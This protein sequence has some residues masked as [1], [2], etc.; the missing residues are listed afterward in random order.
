[1]RL[2]RRAALLGAAAAML[3]ASLPS[4]PA[5]A[6]GGRGASIQIDP[7]FPYYLD[8]SADSIADE[9][10]AN[11]YRTV[12]YFVVNELDVRTE[13]VKALRRRGITVW[14]MVVGLG[15]YS[16]ASWPQGWESWQMELLKPIDLGGFH[17]FS[18]FS[19]DYV[20]FKSGMIA[21]MLAATP[22]DGIEVAEPY[23][24]DWE[25]IDKGY[26]GDVG[27]LARAAFQRE[28][29]TAIP[30]FAD[31]A[32]PTYY[33]TD[34]ARYER[35]IQF[36]VDAVNRCV[37]EI[38]GAARAARPDLKVATWSL[39]VDG[40]PDSVARERE[41]QGL[42]AAAMVALVKPDVHIL[43]TNWP[44]WVKPDLPPDYI[45]AYQPF[46]DQIRA[47]SPRVPIGVQTDIGSQ[48]AMARDDAWIERFTQTVERMGLAT[49]MA[50]E[51]HLGAYIYENPPI[52]T[53]AYIP[54]SGA[55]ELSFQKRID[56][57]SARRPESFEVITETSRRFV[58]P[59]AVT[60]DGNRVT[61]LTR[62]PSG[63]LRVAVRNVTDAPKYWLYDKTAPA[64]PV[65]PGAV[66]DVSRRRPEGA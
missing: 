6:G 49:W 14:A 21:R 34:T 37:A 41:F 15:S 10:L 42:D 54:N 17:F 50:Y 51:Y 32:S 39:A 48:R 63:R 53:S 60:V 58:P 65:P 3:P 38:A 66:V 9:L 43:Q 47:G 8:R 7:T 59:E 45:R 30:D 12:H 22:F 11:G 61:L 46:V 28:Y 24:P 2:T 62:P 55:I 31:P 27:P 16:V 64:N 40:G 20:T 18:P 29:G 4:L 5:Y 23:F 19:A 52:P 57:D 56:P 13:L 25:G 36:R 35:W 44:D 1:M 26:Y 33:R